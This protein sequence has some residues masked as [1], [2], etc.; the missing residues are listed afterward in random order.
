MP[1]E[2]KR[3]RP[4]AGASRRVGSLRRSQRRLSVTEEPDSTTTS[5]ASDDVPT[6]GTRSRIWRSFVG[7]GRGQIIAAVILFVVG[8]GGVMQIRINTA[9]DTYTGARREDLI[10]LLDGLGSE[11]R[12]LESEIADLE[13]T[14]TN[15]QSGADTQRVARE[16][17]EKRA[18]ELAILAGTVPSE[19]PGIRM[20]IADPGGKV[21]AAVLLDAVEELRDAGAEVIEV[22]N[23]IRVVASTWF[24]SDAQGL[25]IDGKPVARPITLE[26]IGDPQTLEEAARFRGGI[27][28]EIT[29]PTIGGQV[30]IDQEDLVV[31]ESLHAARENQYAQPAS[32]PPTPR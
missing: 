1:D 15:L 4:R 5:T 13:E 31:I 22:N 6:A 25:L 29:G 27:V 2:A 21:D 20:R 18:T 16:E 28:S 24:G 10:Q 14:R 7:P 9:D 23:T 8:L 17:A 3:T 32:P 26:V 11:S 30:Q 12:R 19:G